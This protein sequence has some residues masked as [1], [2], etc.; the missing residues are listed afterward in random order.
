MRITEIFYSIQGE[1][2]FIGMPCVFIRTTGCN[3]RCVWCDTAYAFYGGEEM[4]LDE[5]MQKVQRYGCKLVEITGGEPMLQKEIYQLCDQL[6]AA[7]YTVLMET[8]GSLDLSRLDRRVIKIV[9]I[10]CP[11]SGE[12]DR[13]YWPNLD[14]LQP[15]DQ[16][17]FVVKDRTDYEW[18]VEIIRRY[19]L[20]ERFH[21]L[22]SPVF[23]EMDLRTLAECMLADRVKARLQ[24]QLHKF[25]W[26]PDM[27][28][29]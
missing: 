10:K 13:N 28:G 4:S 6:L 15:H 16:I 9:D 5:I 11:G 26:P 29:V 18:A 22:F 17:K 2:S 19:R 12:A 23:G 24:I 27:R 14:I 20:D 21:L 7:E 25:I 1:S 8:G 3:L